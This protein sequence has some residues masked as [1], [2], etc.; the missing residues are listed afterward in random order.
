MQLSRL[1]ALP[2]WICA[3]LPVFADVT[4]S[5]QYDVKTV[6]F[7]PSQA[8]DILH[9]QSGQP[10]LRMKNGKAWSHANGMTSITDLKTQQMTLIDSENQ[11]I[12][13]LGAGELADKLGALVAAQQEQMKGKLPEEARKHMDEMLSSMKITTDSKKTGRTETIQGVQ[14]DERQITITIEIPPPPGV[15]QTLPSQKI[16][17]ALWTAKPEEIVRNQAIRELAGYTQW[18]NIFMNPAG[19]IGK[20]TGAIGAAG[21]GIES[22]TKEL[23]GGVLLRM[24]MSMYMT[25]SPEVMQA[26]AKAKGSGAPV[27]PNAP[28]MEMTTEVSQLST[29]PVDDAV[30]QVPADYKTIDASDFLKN[31]LQRQMAAY[32]PER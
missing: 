2:L 4:V 21:K 19:M 6:S 11:T 20:I 31:M 17:M 29:A 9:E 23:S 14:A 15:S 25:A 27:D 18:T 12:S 13:T 10:A 3:T 28:I 16:V 1:C 7:M 30:L 32:A 8:K 24:Q 22:I 26:I 5:Y